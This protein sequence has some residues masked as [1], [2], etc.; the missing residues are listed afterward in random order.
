MILI[1]LN[2]FKLFIDGSLPLH[3]SG[4]PYI[5][6]QLFCTYLYDLLMARRAIR[7]PYK[8]SGAPYIIY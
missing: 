7:E 6:I 1:I 2:Y 4:A 8:H 3:T 5:L